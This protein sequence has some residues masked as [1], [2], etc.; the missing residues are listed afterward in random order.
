M[1]TGDSMTEFNKDWDHELA[2]ELAQ[3]WVERGQLSGALFDIE[4]LIT[5]VDTVARCGPSVCVPSV[6][7]TPRVPP[8]A[9]PTH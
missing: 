7:L 9:M 1:A 4:E 3:L 8:G 5:I 2:A 6:T